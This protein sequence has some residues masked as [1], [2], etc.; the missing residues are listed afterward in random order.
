[1]SSTSPRRN[2]ISLAV[3]ASTL[4]LAGPSGAEWFGTEPYRIQILVDGVVQDVET[5][6]DVKPT[7]EIHRVW[8]GDTE[9]ETPSAGELTAY[10]EVLF[11]QTRKFGRWFVDYGTG[12]VQS[13][14]AQGEEFQV[15][16][17][18]PSDSLPAVL[19]VIDSELDAPIRVNPDG[20]LIV[21]TDSRVGDVEVREDATV[22]V[23]SASQI[24]SVIT[25]PGASVLLRNSYAISQNFDHHGG[26]LI[27]EDS[28]VRC[29]YSH[30]DSGAHVEIRAANTPYSDLQIRRDLSISD[31]SLAVSGT[32]ATSYNVV[33]DGANTQLDVVAS[34]WATDILQ[35]R[36]GPLVGP[37]AM[38]VA[39]GSHVR[40]VLI[41]RVAGH[42]AYDH[43]TV[44]GAGTVMETDDN[45]NIGEYLAEYGRPTEFS[46]N[47]TVAEG[48]M[49]I[50]HGTLVLKPLGVLTIRSGATV[51]AASIRN[52]GMII[53]DGGTLV[54]PEPV[55]AGAAAAVA[56][57][58][59]ARR[60]R[61]RR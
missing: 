38:T 16:I 57:A 50:V 19:R 18:D 33:M 40:A 14:V 4:L 60:R 23:T 20:L 13:I 46:G 10:S 26:T 6:A 28:L 48:A 51:H 47:V 36:P 5:A 3:L 55:A 34:N 21:R 52:E 32:T 37:V 25:Y 7:D 11:P 9:G 49:L 45:L 44:T 58:A 43:L 35:L 42:P 54:A 61:I 53:E 17:E 1:M 39:G 41:A 29:F 59:L 30:L 2:Q 12:T 56:L 27:A 22:R 24:G 31:S 15:G 8:I